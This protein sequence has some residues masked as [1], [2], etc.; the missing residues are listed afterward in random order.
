ML[1]DLRD[2]A[3]IHLSLLFEINILVLHFNLLIPHTFSHPCQR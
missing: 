1:Y 2:P 3:G